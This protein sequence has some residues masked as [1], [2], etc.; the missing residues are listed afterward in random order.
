MRLRT[1]LVL[2]ALGLVFLAAQRA[3]RAGLADWRYSRN[4]ENSIRAAICLEP[5]R[6]L[7]YVGLSERL[8]AAEQ[9]SRAPLRTAVSLKPDDAAIRMRLGLRAEQARDF[10][11]AE[12]QLLEAARRAKKFQPRWTL[13]NYYFRRGREEDF[14]HWSKEAFHF[15]YGNR[16]P[17]FELCWRMSPDAE[18]ILR[19]A[20]PGER[21]VR[22]DFAAF[23]MGKQEWR[24]AEVLLEKTSRNASVTEQPFFLGAIDRLLNASRIPA[25]VSIW[26]SLCIRN[27][28]DRGVLSPDAGRVVTNQDFSKPALGHAFGWRVHPVPGA[29]VLEG[30]A[31]GLRVALS[32]DQADRCVLLHEAVPLAAGWRYEFSSVYRS[33]PT[34]GAPADTGSGL[35]WRL[36]WAGVTEPAAV[37]SELLAEEG[38]HYS[39][40]EF[41]VPAGVT[42]GRLSLVHRRDPGAV[43]MTG[44][45]DIIRV[46]IALAR[47]F[48]AQ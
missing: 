28:I 16:M 41:Q 22:R 47:R 20:V 35:R 37:E 27:V 9:E 39:S 14:W 4:T 19:R 18:I 45:V 10:A 43:R 46:S 21:A 29:T 24:V 42:G 38:V 36:E 11:E 13:A 44:S 25:A 33:I 7:Y 2:P 12:Q 23:L 17:L 30:S 31:P 34:D 40:T 15:S 26:N 8:D 32:G 5:R 48:Q 6:A 3:V 1:A